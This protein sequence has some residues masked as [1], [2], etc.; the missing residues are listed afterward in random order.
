MD[1]S[2]HYIEMCKDALRFIPKNII[3]NLDYH[4]F[5]AQL[6]EGKY[7][8]DIRGFIPKNDIPLFR[9]DQSQGMFGYDV[10]HPDVLSILIE[11]FCLFNDPVEF[12]QENWSDHRMYLNQFKSM[13]QRWFAFVMH[14]LHNRK[15]A[16]VNW[17]AI[18]A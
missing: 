12:A 3:M 7:A 14:A 18:A 15:W 10:T 17:E 2:N 16:V 5:W 6:H 13:E 11:R 4:T 8:I 9:Q 1:T